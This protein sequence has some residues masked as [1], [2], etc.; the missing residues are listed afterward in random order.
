MHVVDA[1]ALVVTELSNAVEKFPK[2]N[3]RHEGFAVIKEELDELWDAIKDKE[4]TDQDIK[5]EATQVAAM[6]LRFLTD[7]C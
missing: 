7:L 6:G 5:D 3:S 4:A 2:F 1:H